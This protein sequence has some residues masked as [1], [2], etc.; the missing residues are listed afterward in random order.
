MDTLRKHKKI[1]G[2]IGVAVVAFAL[3]NFFLKPDGTEEGVVSNAPSQ[4]PQAGREILSLLIDLKEIQLNGELFQSNA[5]QSFEDF[6]IPIAPEPKG[7]PNPF[8]PV[9]IDQEFETENGEGGD[10][11]TEGAGG[12]GTPPESEAL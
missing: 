4:Q 7:R 9:G 8:A 12:A 5:F 10:T 11:A 1:L 2:I 6:S 3:Y